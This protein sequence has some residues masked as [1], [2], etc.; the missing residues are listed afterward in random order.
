MTKRV[1]V[2]GGTF[3][4][5]HY[6]HLRSAEEVREHFRLDQVFFVPAAIPPHKND[7][8]IP[9]ASKRLRMV[10]LVLQGNRQFRSCRAEI[11]R[12]GRSYSVDTI[13]YFRR[14][15]P[16]PNAVYFILGLDA[17]L[18]IGSWKNYQDLFTLCD[19]IVT[20]R[21]GY[22][23][24]SYLKS[25][26]IEIQNELCYDAKRQV[27][28]H[29]SGNAIHFL[30]ITGLEISASTI[31]EKVKKGES[32]RYLTADAVIQFIENHS[33]YRN[34]EDQGWLG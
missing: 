25:L 21:P 1:G 30:R 18:E 15:F 16:E 19:L 8:A 13:R 27:G 20:S 29:T 3:N 5:I 14:R 7:P 10:E 22:R 34:R 9:A 24:R 17:F 2:L 11:S 6:G 26:P 23:S 32:I 28:V 12:K 33:L 31:R 4:P